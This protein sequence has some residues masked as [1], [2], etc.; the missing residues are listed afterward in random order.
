MDDHQSYGNGFPPGG[1]DLT[2]PQRGKRIGITAITIIYG[3][4]KSIPGSIPSVG[5]TSR[6]GWNEI[7]R[8]L[9]SA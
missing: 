8:T 5:R 2:G 3:I 9:A 1:T 7:A 4:E 6:S